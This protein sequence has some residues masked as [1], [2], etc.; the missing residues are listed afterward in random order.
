MAVA[1]LQAD[2]LVSARLQGFGVVLHLTGQG[3]LCRMPLQ[4]LINEGREAHRGLAVPR[5]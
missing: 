5:W 2:L 1:W 3:S 4:F